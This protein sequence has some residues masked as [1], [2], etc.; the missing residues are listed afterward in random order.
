[1]SDLPGNDSPAA[2]HSPPGVFARG[3]AMGMAEAIPGISGGTIAFIT[4]IYDELLASI[5]S[6]SHTSV[7]TL[8]RDGPGAFAR[9][10]NLVFLGVLVLGMAVGLPLTLMLVVGLLETHAA[11]VTGFFFGLIA[12]SV[13]QVGRQSS[14]R[15]LLT[16][17]L[18]GGLAGVLLGTLDGASPG[19]GTTVVF[20]AGALAATAWILPGMSGA[21]VLVL[22]GLYEPMAEALLG[23]DLAVLATFGAGLAVGLVGFSKLLHWLLGKARG[24]VLALLT[25]LM[26]GSLAQL[27]PWRETAF[28]DTA[29]AGVVAAMV[30][31]A[32]LVGVLG[33]V[34]RRK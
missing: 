8:L 15:W 19:L 23:A 28:A 22:L 33:F 6:F 3:L 24:A 21:F 32:V 29:V 25:G 7:S 34:G 2:P 26:A 5:A 10:H 4:G 30:A 14:W 11:Y 20:V 31:G 9:R 17:G 16:M 27:W 12:A 1:M 13:C 18:V